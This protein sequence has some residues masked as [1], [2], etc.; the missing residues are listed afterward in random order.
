MFNFSVAR[1]CD[2]LIQFLT[3]SHITIPAEF[4]IFCYFP[5]SKFAYEIMYLLFTYNFLDSPPP[6]KASLSSVLEAA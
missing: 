6:T 3:E 5:P 1:P 4:L 2:G